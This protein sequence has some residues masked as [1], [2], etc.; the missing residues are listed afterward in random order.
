GRGR[1]GGGGGGE[2]GLVLHPADGKPVPLLLT[3]DPEDRVLPLRVDL[4]RQLPEHHLGQR[5]VPFQFCLPGTLQRVVDDVERTL[6][7]LLDRV[8]QLVV[9]VPL[10]ADED[11][12]PVPL[13]QVVDG[14]LHPVGVGR[15]LGG[16]EQKQR[17]V[18]LDWHS[19]TSCVSPAL[20]RV[21]TTAREPPP[22]PDPSR[23]RGRGATALFSA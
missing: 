20:R 16:V 7:L 19:L 9:V 4:E 5:E 6:F 12:R 14:L 1:G 13:Q 2:G 10:A 8:R 17:L 23:K 21:V 11:L 18:S 22:A 3:R 15:D